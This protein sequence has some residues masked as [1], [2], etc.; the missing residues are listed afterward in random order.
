[1]SNHVNPLHAILE[2]LGCAESSKGAFFPWD[3]VKNWPSGVLDVLVANGLLQP[4]QP[5]AAIECDGC[6]E[7]CINKPV[8]VYPSQEDK[9]G[10]A[11]I[12]CD[13]H[14]DMGRIHV[15]FDRMR[16]W[17]CSVDAVCSF[18]AASLGLRHGNKRRPTSADFLEIGMATGDKRSQMLCLQTDGELLLVAGSSKVPLADLIEYHD[19]AYSVNASMVR[20][21]VDAGTPTAGAPATV[22]E[23]PCDVFL[24]MESL[25]ASELTIA[26]V[27]DKSE[28]GLG[29]NNMLE[30]VA[31]KEI[32]RVALAVLELVDR[33]GGSANSQGVV[34]LGMALK[35]KL[36]HTGAN[37]A[38]MKR[39]RD[40]FRAHLGIRGDPFE[41]YR[42]SAGWV[43]HKR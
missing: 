40:V 6:E 42:Q 31:R 19:G 23:N 37:A 11:F 20:L 7:N 28:T 5:A 39:V 41:P 18:V 2:R 35:K 26:F 17:Q 16:Q 29:A 34:L 27:G 22:T 32:R 24:A 3:E 4:A 1:M 21:L 43:P 13:E 9:P 10:R 38:K 14:D 33:R 36:T 8:V 25:D 15:S 30:I 12:V